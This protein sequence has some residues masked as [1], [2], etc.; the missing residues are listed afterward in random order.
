NATAFL[1]TT[2]V[3]VL[4]MAVVTYFSLR[5]KLNY[6]P[7]QFLRRDLTKN[8]NKKALK[9]SHKLSIF[10]RFRIRVILQNLANYLVLFIGIF[11]ANFLLMFGMAF[12]DILD[13]YQDTI[14]ENMFCKYQYILEVP[15]SA[16]DEDHKLSSMLEMITY[17]R[18]IETENEDAE[19]FTAY[20]LKSKGVEGIMDDDISI[21]GIAKDSQYIDADI[22]E[23][24]VYISSAY[25]DK[26]MYEIGDEFKLY[27]EYGDEV[28]EFKVDGIYDYSSAMVVFMNQDDANELF[29]FGRSYFSG[30]FSD[31]EITDISDKYISTVIDQEALTKI[32]R[33]LIKSMGGVMS[34]MVMLSI[35]IF[36]VVIYLLSKMIIEKNAQSISMTKILGY[37]GLEISKLYI[38]AT[39]IVTV[40]C[41]LVTI[42][43][44]DK[45]IIKV[46][47]TMIRSE[48]HG[49]FNI[50]VSDSIE[51]KMFVM[52]VLT[53]AVVAIFEFIKIKR[54]PMDIA[55]KNED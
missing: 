14:D 39:S 22:G 36:L 6:S 1:Q 51:I 33:Q 9:L 47:E 17:Q 20:S 48:M 4:I 29:E 34:L 35:F 50:F 30:Y 26:Y 40:L 19:K 43:L 32:S 52:G 41:I 3:P 23:N 21:Y 45:L 10:S 8:K 16:M 31:S 28:Y 38:V 37:S 5:R 53:Y 12:P 44:L 11:L 55:L 2:V 49:W 7:L 54:I 25:A 18:E 46:F 27:E 15:I 13:Y 24:E 42:P